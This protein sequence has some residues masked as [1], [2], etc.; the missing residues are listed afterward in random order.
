MTKNKRLHR[1]LV[2][3]FF[4]NRNTQEILPVESINL[5][6]IV[7]VKTTSGQQIHINLIQSWKQLSG[8]EEGL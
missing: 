5:F 8:T 1:I 7:S 2:Q 6:N 4:F 3:V